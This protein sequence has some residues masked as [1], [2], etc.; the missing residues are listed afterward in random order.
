MNSLPITRYSLRPSLRDGFALPIVLWTIALLTVLVMMALG[1]VN[2]WVDEA[3]AAEKTFRARQLALSG[4]A[5]AMN[6]NVAP[7]DPILTKGDPKSNQGESYTVEI[8]NDAGLINPNIFLKGSDHI[9][10]FQA[11]FNSWKVAEGD[12]ENAI[13]GLYDWQSPTALRSAHGA[14]QAEYQ[15]IGLEGY[16]PNAPFLDAR[17]MAMVIGFASVMKAKPNWRKYF[18]TYNPGK[19]S[20]R[21]APPEI[22]EDVLGMTP[23]QADAWIKLSAGPDGIIGTADD[24]Q[25]N[26]LDD[27]AKLMGLNSDQQSK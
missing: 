16:P 3:A 9:F 7:N 2:R 20:L 10:F 26:S 22:L 13:D 6:Q 27:A 18:S 21:A 5:I 14:K 25:F 17:E 8:T 15:A 12:Q 19:I 1:A 11:L 4:L 23:E 24:L